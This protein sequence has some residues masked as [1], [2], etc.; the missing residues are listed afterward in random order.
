M[1]NPFWSTRR[2]RSIVDAIDNLSDAVD[3]AS[4]PI[5]GGKSDPPSDQAM[6]ERIDQLLLV[7]AAMWELLREKTGATEADLVDKIA[8]LDAADGVA[9]GKLTH[10]PQKCVAC[11]RVI[12]PKHQRCLYC[13]A[14]APQETVFKTI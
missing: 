10:T 12:S 11:G 2:S 4:V 13:G 9:D 3:G 8:Q 6:E 14:A 5:S 1:T 7:C